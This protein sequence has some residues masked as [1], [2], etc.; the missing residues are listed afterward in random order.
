ML[1]RMARK[2]KKRNQIH[3]ITMNLH[4]YLEVDTRTKKVLRMK[5]ENLCFELTN[6]RGTIGKAMK[7]KKFRKLNIGVVLCALLTFHFKGVK[8]SRCI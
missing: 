8:K 2:K 3:P 1:Q 5:K 7:L 6:A 4:K